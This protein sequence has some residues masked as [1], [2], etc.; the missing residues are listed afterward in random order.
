[1]T[2][3]LPALVGLSIAIWCA[4]G[5]YF[6]FLI[7]AGIKKYNLPLLIASGPIGWMVAIYIR[8]RSLAF[9]IATYVLVTTAIIVLIKL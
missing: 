3:L 4:S 6:G 1:M 8:T 5:A 7:L 2:A 9:T